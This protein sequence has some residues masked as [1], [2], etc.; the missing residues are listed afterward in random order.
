[1][2]F[3]AIRNFLFGK[4]IWLQPPAVKPSHESSPDISNP[5]PIEQRHEDKSIE[6]SHENHDD[7]RRDKQDKGNRGGDRGGD[8]GEERGKH[9]KD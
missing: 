8:R 1:M 5:K 9:G 7:D 4:P 6:K 2:C 3:K